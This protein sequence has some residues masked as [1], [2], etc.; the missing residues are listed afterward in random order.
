MER[1]WMDL[2]SQIPKWYALTILNVGN[3]FMLRQF[4]PCL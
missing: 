1:A 4:K 2:L 3:Q